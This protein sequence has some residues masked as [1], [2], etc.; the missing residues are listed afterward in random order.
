MSNFYFQMTLEI[1]LAIKPLNQS[2][3]AF[4]FFF[5]KIQA[6]FFEVMVALASHTTCMHS[7]TLHI[8][9]EGGSSEILPRYWE[10]SFHGNSVCSALPRFLM[11]LPFCVKMII[12][13]VMRN[14]H[15][16]LK[17]Q[18]LPSHC[19]QLLG[20]YFCCFCSVCY[21]CILQCG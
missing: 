6:H 19:I 17:Y 12:P 20:N 5:G 18:I 8:R 1:G 11:L 2:L 9:K 7:V 3:S 13:L 4:L 10:C 15:G 14:F 21:A 16:T